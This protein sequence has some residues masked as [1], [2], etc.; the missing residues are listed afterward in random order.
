VARAS[1]SR[2]ANR[3][4]LLRG[5]SFTLAAR[6]TRSWLGLR[7][8]GS[9]YA[10]IAWASPSRFWP[11][12]QLA[13]RARGLGFALAARAMRS[14]LGLHGSGFALAARAMRS[15]LGLHPRGSGLLRDSRYALTVW[16]SPSRLT[17]RTCGSG[18][19]LAACAT[20]SQ[21]ALRTRY[22]GFAL[23]ARATRLQHEL[24]AR[25]SLYA[26]A[27]RASP[28]RLALII[29]SSLILTLRGLDPDLER[30]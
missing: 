2:L 19:A 18:S 26:F 6:T 20:H 16:A 4:T 30:I 25:G 12:S 8:R 29:D 22:S 9:R 24:R 10:L 1:P 7:P 14:R 17:L 11:P 13:L 5:L 21:L 3:A 15:L 28:S 23:A 27:A